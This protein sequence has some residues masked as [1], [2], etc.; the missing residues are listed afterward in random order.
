[1]SLATYGTNASNVFIRNPIGISTA[2]FSL[3][4]NLASSAFTVYGINQT[5]TGADLAGTVEI[6]WIFGATV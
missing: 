4:S 6:A 3:A 1:M 5:N 2:A